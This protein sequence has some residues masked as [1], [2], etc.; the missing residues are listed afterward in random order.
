LRDLGT[1]PGL[2]R[3]RG[4]SPRISRRYRS[5]GLSSWTREGVWNKHR[6]QITARRTLFR[7]VYKDLMVTGLVGAFVIAER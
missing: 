4:R 2:R 6:T 3:L 5:R 7:R 1:L